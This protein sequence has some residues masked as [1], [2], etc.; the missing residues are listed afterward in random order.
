MTDRTGGPGAPNFAH[1]ERPEQWD[2]D[3]EVPSDGEEADVGGLALRARSEGPDHVR[4]DERETRIAQ[5]DLP[6]GT[7]DYV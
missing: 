4:D 2:E 1:R 7:R 6:F 5:Q 3:E